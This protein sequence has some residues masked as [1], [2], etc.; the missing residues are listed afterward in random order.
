MEEL[1]QFVFHLVVVLYWEDSSSAATDR[2]MPVALPFVVPVSSVVFLKE[3]KKSSRNRPGV[4][5]RVPGGLGSQTS[6]HSAR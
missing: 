2:M 6:W 5:Q 3:L 1:V 4:A